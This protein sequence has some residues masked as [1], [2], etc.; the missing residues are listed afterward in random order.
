MA[1]SRRTGTQP[2][3]GDASG[4]SL[5]QPIV[6]MAST[7]DGKGYWLVASDGGIF[8]FG[9]ASFFGSMGGVHLNQPIVGMAATPDGKGYWLVASDGG[10]FT[11]GDASFFGS[12]GGVHLNQPIVGMA[13][14]PDG[15]GYWLVA[16]DGG[17]FTFGDAAFFGSMGGQRINRPMVGMAATPDGKGYWLGRLRRRHLHLRRRRVLRVDG[18]S[19]AKPPGGRHGGDADG[20]GYFELGADGGIFTFGDASSSAQPRPDGTTRRPTAPKQVSSR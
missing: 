16:S 2:F 8:T 3:I 10:I 12:M 17:I 4:A 5:N 13:A 18:W 19:A 14:T 1:S 15:K 9:D 11:F 7:P 6:G 20:K